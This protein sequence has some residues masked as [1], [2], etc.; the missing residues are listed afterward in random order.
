VVRRR[1]LVLARKVDRVHEQ[2]AAIELHRHRDDEV[3]SVPRVLEHVTEDAVFEADRVA[4]FLE[5]VHL[6]RPLKRQRVV[7]AVTP[8]ARATLTAPLGLSSTMIHRE[9]PVLLPVTG[10][11]DD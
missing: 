8:A 1:A 9:A 10:A 4:A 11:A 3:D 7:T 5:A 2:A 6:Q